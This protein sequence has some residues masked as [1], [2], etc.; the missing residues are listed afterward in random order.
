MIAFGLVGHPL[1]HSCSVPVHRCFGTYD[2]R[3]YDMDE[4]QLRALMQ[5]RAFEGLNVTIPYK[6]TVLPYCDVLSQTVR[7]IGSANTLYFRDGKLCAENTDCIGFSDMLYRSGISLVGRKVA[8][9]GTGG[10]AVTAA[11]VAQMEKAAEVITVSRRGPVDYAALMRE[12]RDIEILINAT[13]V[14]MYP[15]ENET[16][17]DPAAFPKLMGVADVIYNPQKTLLL[18]LAEK[19]G[20]PC[21]GGVWMLARQGLESARLFTR[22]DIPPQKAE[23]ACHAVEAYLQQEFSEK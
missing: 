8:V 2:Y 12:H 9:L 10:T 13:P 23:E 4:A 22:H 1:G 17:V 5:S 20:I 14:G 6:K 15:K 7:Q 18:R 11:Y 16:P 3:L 19:R 21:A